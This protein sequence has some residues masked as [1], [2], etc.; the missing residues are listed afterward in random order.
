MLRHT[1]LIDLNDTTD[2]KVKTHIRFNFNYIRRLYLE[3]LRLDSPFMPCSIISYLQLGT[4]QLIT[5]INEY[6]YVVVIN[7]KVGVII[8]TKPINKL[9]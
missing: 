2:G 6:R 1:F 9:I 8:V 5:L 4:N 7:V 3:F